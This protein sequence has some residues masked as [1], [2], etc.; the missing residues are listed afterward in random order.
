[1]NTLK[2]MT[3]TT[4]WIVRDG[5]LSEL[6]RLYYQDGKEIENATVTID[7]TTFDSITDGTCQKMKDYFQD[8]STFLAV[9]LMNIFLF[10]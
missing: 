4:Q 6:R 8:H 3:V 5:E 10:I 2:K 1:M 7:A 9:T